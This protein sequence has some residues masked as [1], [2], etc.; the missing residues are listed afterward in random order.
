MDWK[1]FSYL[2]ITA[3]ISNI[4]AMFEQYCINIAN[5]AAILMYYKFCI[6]RTKQKFLTLPM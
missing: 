4:I 3:Q 1:E 2:L 5:V 6:G